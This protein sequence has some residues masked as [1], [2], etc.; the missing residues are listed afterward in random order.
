[1]ANVTEIVGR[2][3]SLGRLFGM[4]LERV[5]NRPTWLLSRANLRAQELLGAA[6][7]AEGL[8]GY[9]F[10]LLAALDQYGPSSQAVLERRK[11]IAGRDVVA[12]LNELVDERVARRQPDPE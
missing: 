7:A 8:R 5:A 4:T 10:R 11:G 6:F 3:N 1:M 12:A 2:T 9:H